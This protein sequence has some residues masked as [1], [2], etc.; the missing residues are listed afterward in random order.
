MYETAGKIITLLFFVFQGYCLQFFYGS[1]LEGRIRSKPVTSVAAV[2]LYVVFLAAMDSAEPSGAGDYRL[3]AVKMIL[4]VCILY[5][6]ALCFYRAF[7][8]IT[9]FLAVTFQACADITRYLIAILFGETGDLLINLLNSGFKNGVITSE[10]DFGILLN[11]TVVGEWILQ[12]TAIVFLLRFSLKRI[13]CYYKGKNYAINGTELMFIL[14]PSSVGLMICMLL[15]IIMI[16]AEDGVPKLL[17]EKYPVLIAVIP[18]ILL[19]SLLSILCGVKLFQDM[20]YRNRERSG[21]IVLEK[22][23]ASMREQMEETERV[24]SNIRRIKHDMKNTVS[25]IMRL[26]DLNGGEENTELKKYLAELS[27]DLEKSELL[28]KTGNTVADTLLNIKYHEGKRYIEELQIDAKE[29]MFPKDLKIF[30][31][32]IGAVLGNALDNAIEACVKLNNEP[33]T[34][35]FIRLYSMQKNGIFILGIENSFDGKLKLRNGEE[36]PMTDKADKNAHGMGLF[37]IKNTAEKYGGTMDFQVRDKVF[38]LSVMMKNEE[39]K[40]NSYERSKK[41]ILE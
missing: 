29:L 4:S 35:A 18:A 9:V 28:F 7:C 22:Q 30:S 6:I 3:T 12:Y 1:F 37:N 17:Y 38:V 27:G 14:V 10:K 36:L 19:L 25:V 15:R 40:E 41:W 11:C 16:S 20:I 33:G 21:R 26:S 24:Y 23:I 31:Y 2:A 34:E 39:P 32:D 5:I 8:P 13:V